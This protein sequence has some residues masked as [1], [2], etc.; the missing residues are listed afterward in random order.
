MG[1]FRVLCVVSVAMVLLATTSV[2][3][4]DVTVG[5]FILEIA[6][7]R[8]LG[9]AGPDEAE[10]SLRASGFDLPKLSLE[11]PLTEGDVAA[12]SG[13]LGLRV[14]TTRPSAA[15]SVEQIGHFV[16]TFG[17]DL[18]G[19]GQPPASGNKGNGPPREDPNPGKG[20]SKG[21][22]KSPSEPL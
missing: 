17:N 22:H 18:V 6:K 7:I 15:V 9:A 19:L 10:R 2:L 8:H 14:T 4:D 3:A 11:K 13:S 16:A 21:F 5:A 1:R 12:I 20:K